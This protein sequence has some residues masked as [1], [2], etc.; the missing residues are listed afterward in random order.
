MATK[1]IY[2]TPYWT[3]TATSSQFAKLNRIELRFITTGWNHRL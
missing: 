1:Q 3:T 2:T